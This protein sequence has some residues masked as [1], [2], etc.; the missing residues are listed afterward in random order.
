MVDDSY[1]FRNGKFVKRTAEQQRRYDNYFASAAEG[2]KPQR[3]PKRKEPFIQIT[4]KQL[5]R[6]MQ[7]RSVDCV[8]IFFIL[9]HENFRHHGA[10]FIVPSDQITEI[11]GFSLWT[12]RRAI[13]FL[14]KIG[15]IIVQR[16]NRKPP[17]IRV[18]DVA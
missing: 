1:T 4:L 15:L 6:L 10:A 14:E 16:V 2:K 3:T 9:C 12:Q 18:L 5:D 7:T 11:T 8:W 17:V 13:A